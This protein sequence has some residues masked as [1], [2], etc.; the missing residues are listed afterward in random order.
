MNYVISTSFPEISWSGKVKQ[1]FHSETI[2][3]DIRPEMSQ[4]AA[5]DIQ[6]HLQ[7]ISNAQTNSSEVYFRKPMQKLEIIKE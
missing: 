5:K 6:L 1:G 2:Q 3:F 7:S 4:K